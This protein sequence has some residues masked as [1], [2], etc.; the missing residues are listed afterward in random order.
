MEKTLFKQIHSLDESIPLWASHQM[1]AYGSCGPSWRIRGIG[2]Q[3]RGTC[4]PLET[5]VLLGKQ[6][7]DPQVWG[8][9]MGQ[10]PP[11]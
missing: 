7:G 3:P 10:F 8:G 9:R 1:C 6:D 2:Q 4:L 5:F 11:P